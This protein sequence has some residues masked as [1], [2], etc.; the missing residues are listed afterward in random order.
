MTVLVM[1]FTLNL[2]HL[3]SFIFRCKHSYY[4]GRLDVFLHVLSDFIWKIILAIIGFQLHCWVVVTDQYP[5]QL[6]LLRIYQPW[7]TQVLQ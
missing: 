3:C 6:L 7:R 1:F 5:V 4:F 2:L